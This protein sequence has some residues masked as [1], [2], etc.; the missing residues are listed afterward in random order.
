MKSD[1]VNYIIVGGFVILMLTGIVISVAMLAGR[2]GTADT[3]YTS[4]EDVT[5]L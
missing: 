3:Y 1:R 2:T 4:Y 5:G